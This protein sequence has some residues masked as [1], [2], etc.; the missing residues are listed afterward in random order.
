MICDETKDESIG[1]YP[2]QHS[3]DGFA[4]MEDIWESST[5][6]VSTLI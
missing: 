2:P 6:S 1:P 4:H 5:S 3:G